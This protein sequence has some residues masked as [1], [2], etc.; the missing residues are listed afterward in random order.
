M[1]EPARIIPLS[2]GMLTGGY[3][4]FD[5]ITLGIS[6]SS[7]FLFILFVISSLI[8]IF[9][10]VSIKVQY[11]QKKL[12]G[13]LTWMAFMLLMMAS[14]IGYDKSRN[15][16]PVLFSTHFSWGNGVHLTFRENGTFRA[17]EKW[18]L[19]GREVY[20]KYKLEN[21]Y[22]VLDRKLDLRYSN[23]IDTLEASEGGI[24]FAVRD[25]SHLDRW[26]MPY[27]YLPSSEVLFI[28]N[29]KNI[30]DSVAISLNTMIGRREALSLMPGEES[31]YKFKTKSSSSNG[32]YI[33]TY[34]KNISRP[35][36]IEIDN[37]LDGYPLEVVKEIVFEDDNIRIELIFRNTII[38]SY[39]QDLMLKNNEPP[40]KSLKY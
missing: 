7:L 12:N 13:L 27:S 24:F 37:I 19:G 35:Q 40:W 26:I 10:P 18:M 34:S 22:I 15:W 4:F 16:S 11:V 17:Q 38:K 1:Q 29:T 39:G 21:S 8:A 28:N 6:F 23:I 3:I 31:I 9:F 30:I 25:H 2:V 20:G 14:L 36:S 5:Y 32:N 33:L